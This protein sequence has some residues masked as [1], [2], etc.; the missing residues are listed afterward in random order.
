MVK[1]VILISIFL[2][3][4]SFGYSQEIEKRKCDCE[5]IIFSD[6]TLQVNNII[7]L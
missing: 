6:F 5:T 1:K 7:G 2:I 3:W 4:Y